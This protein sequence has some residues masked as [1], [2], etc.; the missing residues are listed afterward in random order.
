MKSRELSIEGAWEFEPPVFPDDRGHFVAPFQSAA[1]RD[2]VGHALTVAQTNHSVSRRGVVRG[3]HFADV[4][5]G[6]A[7]YVYCARGSLLDVVVDVRLDSPTFGDN[8]AVLLEARRGNSVYLSEGLGH[9]FV[10]LDDDTAMV[11]L[12]STGYNP[13]AERGVN[14]LDPDL[15]LPWPSELDLV[16]SDKDRDAP[17]IE[18]ARADGALPRFAACVDYRAG[19]RE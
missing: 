12:C 6:Q 15:A 13:S 10:A 14:P 2:T 19:L 5:P 3:V 4:P 16:L 7:K 9:A 1:F 11:Y 18:A 17:G 8:E